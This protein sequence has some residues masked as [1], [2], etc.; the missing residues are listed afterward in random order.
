[1]VGGNVV[2]HK[3]GNGSAPVEI[4]ESLGAFENFERRRGRQ[5]RKGRGVLYVRVLYEYCCC[6][7]L[8]Y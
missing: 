6:I 3:R 7:Q 4:K 2:H 1:M 8:L 5:L